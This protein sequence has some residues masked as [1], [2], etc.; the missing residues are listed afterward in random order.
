MNLQVGTYQMAVLAKALG[1]PFYA[2]AESYKFLRLFPLSQ[3]DLPPLPSATTSATPAASASTSKP[4][5]P[6]SSFTILPSPLASPRPKPTRLDSDVGSESGSQR[7]GSSGGAGQ[8]P[9]GMTAEMLA[10]N[11]RY[12]YTPRDAI[13]LVI[14]DVG[15]LTPDSVSSYLVI[16]E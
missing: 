8:Q 13:G 15:I 12:D 4:T 2:L 11:P 5:L 9:T 14:S 6:L 3:A 16:A 10:L 7:P 1:K